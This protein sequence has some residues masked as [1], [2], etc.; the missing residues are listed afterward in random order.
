MCPNVTNRVFTSV[1]LLLLSPAAASEETEVFGGSER[2]RRVTVLDTR[3]RASV[4]RASLVA[5]P[6]CH[7]LRGLEEQQRCAGSG[8]SDE[9]TR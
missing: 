4:E 5:A 6:A 3:A 1:R 7:E 8:L 9:P 2:A